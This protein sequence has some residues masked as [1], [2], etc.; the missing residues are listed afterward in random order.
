MGTKYDGVFKFQQFLHR[1]YSMPLNGEREGKMES[2]STLAS[3]FHQ[4]DAHKLGD[5]MC[6]DLG[7]IVAADFA[8]AA[9]DSNRLMVSGSL[10]CD[11]GRA[12]RVSMVPARMEVYIDPDPR[13]SCAALYPKPG[14]LVAESTPGRLALD[15]QCLLFYPHNSMLMQGA[16]RGRV[17]S[18]LGVTYAGELY[19][20]DQPSYE[21][22]LDAIWKRI[23]DYVIEEL[24]GKYRHMRHN[25]VEKI[26]A[27]PVRYSKGKLFTET[28]YATVSFKMQRSPNLRIKNVESYLQELFSNA[29]P[30]HA[31]IMCRA[32]Q[33]QRKP[34]LKVSVLL[35][36]PE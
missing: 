20:Q 11:D 35:E 6:V 25:T 23:D 5:L 34:L 1:R 10:S 28:N 22:W 26:A 19:S 36:L 17:L 29:L 16:H 21:D 18:E 33:S 15:D 32:N 3:F 24:V 13:K 4:L 7:N 2:P 27:A 30:F 8:G 31:E 14:T 12:S 9:L